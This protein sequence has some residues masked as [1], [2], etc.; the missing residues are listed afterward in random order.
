MLSKT[1][2]IEL[3]YRNVFRNKR[4]TLLTMTVIMISVGTLLFFLSYISGLTDSIIG[5]SIK[6][7]G[8]LN[9]QRP[10]Y[11]LKERMMSLTETVEDYAAVR[12]AV[13]SNPGVDV[14]TGR[15][16]F[17]GFI[18]FREE[19][20]PGVGMGVDPAAERDILKLENSIVSGGYFTGGRNETVIGLEFSK[21][22]GIDT[23]DTITV[24]SRT[25]FGSLAAGNFVVVGIADLL[26]SMLNRLFYVPLP[27]AQD[28]LDMDNQVAEIAVFLNNPDDI[29]KIQQEIAVLPGIAGKY[30]VLSWID[31]GILG[32]YL[33]LINFAVGIMIILFGTIA[34]FS[35]I[36]TMLMVVLERTNEIGVFSAF[37]MKRRY[38][39]LVFVFEALVIGA[40]GSLLGLAIGGCGG[41]YLESTGLTVG[42]IAENFSIPIRHKIYGDL[43]WSMAVLSYLFGLG[44][45]LAGALFPALKAARMEPTAALHK[46]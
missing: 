1:Y 36:N 44:L 9:I 27:A 18:D 42:K 7:T 15:I 41:Y 2:L 35:I 38:I 46:P 5:D 23:G 17:G 13:V 16:K 21:K 45:S 43:Q 31:M 29:Q 22:L 4:R 37:G 28:M 3:A 30:S 26:S 39:L 8:H 33:P 20:E 12:S 32:D 25:A 6:A 24:I 10:E 19:N 34:A 14:A 40:C 11:R